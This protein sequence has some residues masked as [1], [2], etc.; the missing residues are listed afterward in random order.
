MQMR[1]YFKRHD[2]EAATTEDFVTA[3][4]RSLLPW[5]VGFDPDQF[6]RWYHQA[7]TP[8]HGHRNGTEK[9][10][11]DAHPGADCSHAGAA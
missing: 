11:T 8:R 3:S 6:R 5:S 1:L 10:A 9:R 2:G 4:S 7:R